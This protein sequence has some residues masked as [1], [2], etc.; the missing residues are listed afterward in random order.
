MK[1]KSYDVA[2]AVDTLEAIQLVLADLHK[3]QLVFRPP[4]LCFIKGGKY[5]T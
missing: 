4:I 3:E 1:I 2:D 5:G